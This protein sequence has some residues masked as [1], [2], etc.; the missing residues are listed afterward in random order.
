VVPLKNVHQPSGQSVTLQ[1]MSCGRPVILS[2]TKGLWARAVL[3]DGENCLLVPPGD[4]QALGDAIARI[5]SDEALAERLGKMAR[6][7]ALACFG[8]D[9]SGEGTLALARLGFSKGS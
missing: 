7:T 2:N 1:A 9:K 8:L 3:R 5:R 4:R 6:E